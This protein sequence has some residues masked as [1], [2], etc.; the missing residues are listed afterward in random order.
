VPYD[1]SQG[2]MQKR[3]KETFGG[4]PQDQHE[5]DAKYLRDV[6]DLYVR[7]ALDRRETWKT[8]GCMKD[9]SLRSIEDIHQE[10][11]SLIDRFT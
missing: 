2:L 11:M 5:Q 6:V 8:I 7:T 9:N 1:V 10:V 3:D 4:R